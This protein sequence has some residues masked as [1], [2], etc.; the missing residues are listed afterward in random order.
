[1]SKGISINWVDFHGRSQSLATELAI[2]AF[3]FERSDSKLL[4]HYWR[5]FRSTDRVLWEERP[6]YI[7]VMQPPLPALIACLPYAL[8]KKATLVGDL[9]TGA[10]LNPKWKWATSIIIQLLRR[11]GAAIVTNERL[12]APLRERNL[13]TIVLH[14]LLTARGQPRIPS[15]DTKTMPRSNDDAYFLVPFGYA[16]DEPI[17]EFL[18]A[19]R[20]TPQTSFILTGNPPKKWVEQAPANVSFSGFVSNDQYQSL[21]E[22]S[23]AVV[24]LTTRDMTMQRAA[25]EALEY[26]KPV[27]TSDFAVLRD[28]FPVGAVFAAPH[29]ASI[30][31]AVNRLEADAERLTAEALGLREV[32]IASQNVAVQELREAIETAK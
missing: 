11:L 13:R 31:E 7:I 24:A 28:Y 29:S 8:R 30:A 21:V 3:F 20:A 17:E 5:C 19:A 1:V 18:R 32:R 4:A 10:L 6:D 9:H 2:Q 23:R 12:A 25:Y 22:R 15:G 27:V 26:G 14:D 16:N